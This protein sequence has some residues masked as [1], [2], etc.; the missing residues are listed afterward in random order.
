MESRTILKKVDKNHFDEIEVTSRLLNIIFDM[1]IDRQLELL[2]LLDS[3]GYNG[4]RRHERT[5]LKNPWV[6]VINPDEEPS[7]SYIKDVSRCG[8]FIE[9]TRSFTIGEKIIMKFQV[10]SSKKIFK[11][12]G[13][14]ARCQQN[15]IG[16]RFRRQLS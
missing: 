16:V 11:I 3:Q 15:G 2:E 13:E 1:P 14:V 4:G 10:P 12:V 5:M 7:D 6:V 8:M 9:T